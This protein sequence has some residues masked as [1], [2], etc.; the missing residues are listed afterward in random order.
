[1]KD[2]CWEEKEPSE[3]QRFVDWSIWV[4]PKIMVL[5]NHPFVHRVFHEINLPFLGARPYSWKHPYFIIFLFETTFVLYHLERIDGI[6]PS[7]FTIVY[8]ERW[9]NGWDLMNRGIGESCKKLFTIMVIHQLGIVPLMF[10]KKKSSPLPLA[11]GE[12]GRMLEEFF[13]NHNIAQS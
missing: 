8:F 1:M 4:F 2:F 6:A 7:T 11:K 13:D 12:F 9:K 5:P 3:F 10:Q